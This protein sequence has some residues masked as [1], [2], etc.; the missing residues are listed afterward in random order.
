LDFRSNRQLDAE[1]LRKQK[2]RKPKRYKR[3]SNLVYADE[4]S[5][6]KRDNKIKAHQ[7]MEMQI[8]KKHQKGNG[9]TFFFS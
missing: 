9:L 3:Y 1:A 8:F 7:E 6:N 5:K 2:L 4:D